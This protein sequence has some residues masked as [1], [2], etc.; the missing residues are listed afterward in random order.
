MIF[1]VLFYTFNTFNTANIL[2]FLI[3]GCYNRHN[4]YL[5]LSMRVVDAGT[6][7]EIAACMKAMLLEHEGLWQNTRCLITD[8]C[9]A[10]VSANRQLLEQMNQDRDADSQVFQVC[11][12]MHT[13][14]GSDNRSG[15][16]LSEDTKTVAS[17]LKQIF[18]GRKQDCFRDVLLNFLYFVSKLTFHLLILLKISKFKLICAGKLA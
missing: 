8:R 12:L 3:I 6:G 4:D 17:A 16:C 11:C 2:N 7:E 18:G 14:L 5:V 9:P 10:Q 15:A 13:V 1:S